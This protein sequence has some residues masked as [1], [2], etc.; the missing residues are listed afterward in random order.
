MFSA[1]YFKQVKSAVC[2]NFFFEEDLQEMKEAQD[3]L[4]NFFEAKLRWHPQFNI[5]EMQ[6]FAIVRS[7]PCQLLCPPERTSVCDT[8]VTSKFV[9]T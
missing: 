1:V 2:Q 7:Y 6:E 5:I 4:M 8:K 3:S 9:V